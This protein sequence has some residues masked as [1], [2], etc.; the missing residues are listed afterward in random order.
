LAGN[1]ATDGQPRQAADVGD[2]LTVV[3]IATNPSGQ[4]TS[5]NAVPVGPV[6]S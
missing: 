5:V 2:Y 1:R 4:Q 6:S 3:V